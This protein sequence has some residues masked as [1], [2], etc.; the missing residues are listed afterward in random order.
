MAE[1]LKT[2]EQGLKQENATLYKISEISRELVGVH[3]LDHL[4]RQIT[5]AAQ[6]I[7]GSDSATIYLYDPKTSQLYFKVALGEKGEDVK[8]YLLALDENSI[9]GWIG[10]HRQSQIVNDLRAAPRH[11][12]KIDREVGYQTASILGV[13][14]LYR[15]ELLGVLEALNKKEGEF[16]SNDENFLQLLADQAAIA[17]KNAQLIEDL[18]NFFINGIELLITALEC[19]APTGQGHAFRVTRLATGI[20]R[21]LGIRDKDYENIYYAGLLHD[22]GLLKLNSN[23]PVDLRFHPVLGAD[24]VSRI[25]LL[26][27]I[28]PLIRYHHE[29]LDGSG[30]PEALQGEAVPRDAQILGLAEAWDEEFGEKPCSAQELDNFLDANQ[31]KFHSSVLDA[32]KNIYSRG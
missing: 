25:R 21:Y 1:P 10:L 16:D 7:T 6:E 27:D 5:L 11:Y 18:K 26:E 23:Q 29:R 32:L 19:P 13:P 24:M 3:D 9:A 22:I 30:Y 28:A 4:L 20:A 15:G 12:K 14:M 2:V 8:K 17:I 31:G